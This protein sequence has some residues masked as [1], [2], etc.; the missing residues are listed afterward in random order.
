VAGALTQVAFKLKPYGA[1]WEL[2][3]RPATNPTDAMIGYDIKGGSA[4]VVMGALPE[5]CI[6][7]TS[8]VFDLAPGALIGLNVGLT[9]G[10]LGAYL[11]DQSKYGAA[12]QRGLLVCLGAGA[13]ARRA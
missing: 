2:S 3:Y 4:D 6:F 7:R 8:S 10:L 9:G 5:K 13:A 12:V 1:D 11:C